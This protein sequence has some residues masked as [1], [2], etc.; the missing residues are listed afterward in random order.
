MKLDVKH[1]K[2]FIHILAVILFLAALRIFWLGIRGMTL[3]GLMDSL[4]KIP[5]FFLLLSCVSVALSYWLSTIIEKYAVMD[6]GLEL[7]YPRVARISFVSTAIG[8]SV[9]ALVSGAPFRYRYYSQAGAKPLQIGRIVAATQ[10]SS[11]AGAAALNGLVL[12]LWPKE[13][14]ALIGF[15]SGLRYALTLG[16]LAF[17]L[18][19]ILVSLVVSQRRKNI[20]IYGRDIPIPAP[21]IMARQL[22][23]GFFSPP[24]TAL[25]LFF[26][27]P[28]SQG[29]NFLVFSGIF[30]LSSMAG[31]VS[32]VP[33]GIGVFEAALVWMLRSFYGSAELLSAILLYRLF[34]NL[35]PFLIAAVLLVFDTFRT[36]HIRKPVTIADK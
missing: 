25:V 4:S 27:L 8:A 13:I 32:M 26:L 31:A 1:F 19:L 30:A 9:G 17:P 23:A 24:A 29:V 33:A 36:K 11:W 16:C 12:F 6:S 14:I 35:L 10:L 34:N 15:P 5:R 3:S 18:S 22:A 28:A 7:P 20:T 21:K 2:K